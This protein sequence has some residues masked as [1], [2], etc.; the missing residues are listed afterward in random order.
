[1]E[2]WSSVVCSICLVM[3]AVTM[4]TMTVV[5]M[6]VVPVSMATMPMERIWRSFTLDGVVDSGEIAGSW[7]DVQFAKKLVGTLV[8][9]GLRNP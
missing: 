7:L 1:M 3:V 9:E 5:G 8:L 2:A 4:I 6:P